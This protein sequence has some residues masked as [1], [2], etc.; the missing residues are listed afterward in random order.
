MFK[1]TG[2]GRLNNLNDPVLNVLKCNCCRRE[3]V[4]W[5]R[6]KLRRF[7][8][9]SLVGILMD[10]EGYATFCLFVCLRIKHKSCAENTGMPWFRHHKTWNNHTD[11]LI[12]R[13]NSACYAIRAVNAMLSWKA[14]R[15]LCFSYVH[16]IISYGII[17][18]GNTLN[19]IKILRMQKK[20]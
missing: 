6:V 18:G 2:N 5:R 14:L 16:S 17:L 3:N 4:L 20:S 13:R 8:P 1:K 11:Q 10:K 15:M 7:P 12:P 9:T 19:S